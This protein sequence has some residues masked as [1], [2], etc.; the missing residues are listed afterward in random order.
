MPKNFV[1][2]VGYPSY[3]INKSGVVIGKS[4]RPL[5]PRKMQPSRNG[6]LAYLMVALYDGTGMQGRSDRYVHHLVLETFVGPRPEGMEARHLNGDY[7]DNRLQNLA[8]GTKAQNMQDRIKH[9]PDCQ[10]CSKPLAG[11]NLMM[12]S[13][14]IRRVRICRSCHN[15]RTLANYHERKALSV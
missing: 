13:N 15:E 7:S 10:K 4:G 2:V 1:P 8:W 3:L 6:N 14:G 11:K 5:K 9:H 12:V